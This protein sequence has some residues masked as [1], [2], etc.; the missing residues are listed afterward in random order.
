[1]NKFNLIGA[2]NGIDMSEVASVKEMILNKARE[3]SESISAGKEDSVRNDVMNEARASIANPN[4]KPFGL[5][6]KTSAKIN[7]PV[8][9]KSIEEDI[10]KLKHNVQ[11]A[12]NSVYTASMRDEV[13]NAASSGYRK[14][15]SLNESLK[16]LNTQAAI[17]LVS[18]TH[19]KIT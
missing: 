4:I 9:E 5:I 19:S 8:V 11:S 18:K 1:M 2:R 12:D 7:E 14:R 6:T 3:K 16:F 13:M 17:R 15:T 10:P